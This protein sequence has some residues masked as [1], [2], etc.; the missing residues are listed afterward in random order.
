MQPSNM[1]NNR[2]IKD[3]IELSK[4]LKCLYSIEAALNKKV[5]SIKEAF[6]VVIDTIPQGMLYGDKAVVK[7]IYEDKVFNSPNFLETPWI[8]S[9][10]LKIHD[11][12]VGQLYVCYKQR[13]PDSEGQIFSNEEYKLIETIAQRLSHYILYKRLQ[14]VVEEVQSVRTETKRRRPEW[15][16]IL[17]MIRKTDPNLFFRLLRKLLH[18]LCWDGVAG[19]DKL[20]ELSTI[21]QKIGDK[22]TKEDENKPLKKKVINTYNDYIEAIL[23]LAYENISREQILAKLLKWI[24]EDKSSGL[25]KA[26]ESQDTSL[27]EISDSIR[28]YF[29][30]APEKFEVSESTKK[31]LRVSLLRR[32]FTDQLGYINIAKEYV[33]ITDFYKIID[34]MVFPPSSH[35]K[36]GGKS[37]GLFLAKNILENCAIDPKNNCEIKTPKTWYI[38]SDG[39]MYF[40]HY[41]DLEEVLE[42]KYKDINEVR[43]EYAQIVQVFKN[44]QFPPDMVKGL[45][46]ALDDF[47]DKPLIVR[48]SSLMEDQIGAAFSGKYK[49]LFLA[50]QGT[51]SEK[52]AALLDAVA[53]VYA[54]TFGQDPIEYR[55]EKGL[56]DFHEEMGIMIQEVVGNKVGKYFFPAFAGVAFSYNEFRWSPRINRDDGLVR[57]VPGL[58]TRAVD[59]IGDDYPVLAAPG[60][61]NL[62]VNI[63]INETLKYSPKNLDVI[64]LETNDFETIEIK[65]L[66]STTNDE[67]P[68][69]SNIFSIVT[70]NMI[71]PILG[72]S[73]DYN[74]R[75]LVANFDGLFT[76]TNFLKK[77]ECNIKNFT[78]KIKNSGRY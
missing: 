78:R 26:L 40:M 50:N 61:P 10:E 4:E 66:L 71:R 53:E 12:V 28:R 14:N 11:K 9:F 34:K 32:F 30:L 18:Q 54:S 7:I 48:S 51:K 22:N 76:R 38:A 62:R 52:L 21:E 44:S 16:V 3:E 35:G 70:G 1:S 74:P 45:A 60:Q 69:M 2:L 63:T 42:Q 27:M 23:T 24:K 39:I 67:Y 17:D 77:N 75:D 73:S 56:I 25:I 20:L 72:I 49:S 55:I 46:M 29:H 15:R 19:A 13:I 37:A 36:L 64:N 8:L 43:L 68:Q 57:L 59:R 31:G 65:E 47:G 58:G 6:R 5:H 41:N 33:K